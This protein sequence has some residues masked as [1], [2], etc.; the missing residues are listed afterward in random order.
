MFDDIVEEIDAIRAR[1]PA[2][3][4][5]LDV[6]TSYPSFHVLRFHRLSHALWR[7]RWYWLS[8][9]LSQWGRFWTGI[10]IHPAAKIGRR[11]F[12]D[13]GMG[14]VIGEFAEIG[15]DVTLYHGVT[16]GGI[17]P[18]VASS[19]QVGKKRHPTLGSN[20]IVGSGAQ[21][22]GP[23]TIGNYARVGSNSVVV[24]DV[25]E[26]TT[27][28]G[29]PAKPVGRS[30]VEKANTSTTFAAYAIPHSKDFDVLG[31]TL[32][33]LNAQIKELTAKL[34]TLEQELAQAKQTQG[35]VD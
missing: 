25:P 10:E 17:S 2:A 26:H 33:S 35:Q 23:V 21:I 28:I 14:V 1:D 12:I 34:E 31:D 32:D 9:N 16:L 8:R 3:R 11:L 5:R 30:P 18:S 19:T 13:H 15:D 22:L 6:I 27:V 4:T 29:I 24:K 20:V 7:R